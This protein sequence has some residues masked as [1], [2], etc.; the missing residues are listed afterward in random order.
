[1]LEV[2]IN[3]KD[4]Q[5]IMNEIGK[6]GGNI[7]KNIL[8]VLGK[9]LLEIERDAK[10]L[11]P[12]DTGRLRSSITTTINEDKKQGIIYTNVDYSIYVHEG[13]R[14]MKGRPFLRDAIFRDSKDI[15]IERELKK[16][17]LKK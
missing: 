13:T 6:I 3:L 8:E 5:K 10:Y 2:K 16:N 12:V 11:A 9:V 14:K 4:S 1:M 15:K 7:D 17:L